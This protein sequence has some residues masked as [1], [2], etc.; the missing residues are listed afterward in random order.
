MQLDIDARPFP[1]LSN[2][3]DDKG[4]DND[5]DYLPGYYED[6]ASGL[7]IDNTPDDSN[8]GY[9]FTK[10]TRDRVASSLVPFAMDTCPA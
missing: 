3:L 10:D 1:A 9:L 6:K 5:S 8:I 7:V 2:F 4:E